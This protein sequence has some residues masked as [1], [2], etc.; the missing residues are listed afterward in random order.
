MSGPVVNLPERMNAAALLVDDNV[1]AGRGEKTAIYDTG[2]DS[3][4][5]YN[6]VLTMSNRTGNALKD[7]GVRLE[8]RVMLLL[9]DSPELVSSF[10]GAIKIGAVPIPANTLLRPHGYEYMLNDSR[11]RVLVVS[12]SLLEQIEPIKDKHRYLRQKNR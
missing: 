11:A 10:F 3:A 1:E 12:E 7:L 6:D 8:E 2:D 5:T 9:P 4:L